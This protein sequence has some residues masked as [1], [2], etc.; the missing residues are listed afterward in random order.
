MKTKDLITYSF[1]IFEW[2]ELTRRLRISE[3]ELIDAE[4]CFT[5]RDIGKAISGF[6]EFGISSTKTQRVLSFVMLNNQNR[7][8][9]T[10]LKNSEFNIEV[11]IT[12]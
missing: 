8:Y 12:H 6:A 3:G 9:Q 11:I 7:H 4:T 1:D 10:T 5:D 2:D